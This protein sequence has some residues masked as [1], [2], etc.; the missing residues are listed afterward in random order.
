[1][2]H[3]AD[4]RR[5]RGGGRRRRR[6]ADP[7]HPPRPERAEAGRGGHVPGRPTRDRRGRHQARRGAGPAP[8]G[9]ARDPARPGDA[10]GLPTRARRLRGR[11]VPA[12]GRGDGGRHHRDHQDTQGRPLRPGVRARAARRPTAAGATRPVLFDPAHGPATRDVAWAPPGGVEREIPVCFRDAQRLEA[13]ERP[14][15]RL[16]RLGNRQ[17]PWFSSGPLYAPWASGWYDDAVRAGRFEA[18]RLTMLYAP[19]GRPHAHRRRPGRRGLVRPRWLVRRRHRRGLGPRRIRRR[20]WLRRRLRRRLRRWR[21]R[22]GWHLGGQKWWSRR[23]ASATEPL[24]DG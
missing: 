8:R 20:R 19:L 18:D 1:M 9:D 23:A 12:R 16:V 11:Q 13:G 5:P 15:V 22:R 2:P 24:R 21:W 3:G 10:R 7:A 14:E 17:V 6:L 4:R